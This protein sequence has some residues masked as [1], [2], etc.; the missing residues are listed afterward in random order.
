[1]HLNG[2][3]NCAFVSNSFTTQNHINL[4]T[5]IIKYKK[6]QTILVLFF[7]NPQNTNE[8][9]PTILKQSIV[10]NLNKILPIFHF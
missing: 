4:N 7:I 10:T 3:K 9:T 2:W 6:K 5:Q 1:M 8:I